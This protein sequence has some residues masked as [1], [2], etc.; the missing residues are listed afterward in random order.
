VKG[1][2][3]LIRG[4]RKDLREKKNVRKKEKGELGGGVNF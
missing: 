3:A 2:A 1:N 4:K